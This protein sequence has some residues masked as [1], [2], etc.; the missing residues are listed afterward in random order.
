MS[1]EAGA[2]GFVGLTCLSL[3]MAK[4]RSKAGLRVLPRPAVARIMGW[5]LLALS[6]IAAIAASGPAMGVVIWLGELSVAAALLVL[7]MSWRP[8]AAPAAA[9]L[10][11]AV[12]PLAIWL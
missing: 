7:L 2:L 11:L 5:L 8:A 1:L 6:V 4:H 10:A 9:A 3:A 12:V